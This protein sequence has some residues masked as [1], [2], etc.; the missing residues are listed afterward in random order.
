M[1]CEIFRVAFLFNR[2]G[3]I[4]A[5]GNTFKVPLAIVFGTKFALLV[6]IVIRKC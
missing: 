4:N 6:S 1:Q 3:L 5:A 2:F